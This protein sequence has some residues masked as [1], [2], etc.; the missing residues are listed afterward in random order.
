MATLSDMKLSQV[1]IIQDHEWFALF[2][3]EWNGRLIYLGEGEF[4]DGT[5]YKDVAAFVEDEW[6]IAQSAAEKHPEALCHV[7]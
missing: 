7:P 2:R 4:R 1:R 6:V 5:S 3:G